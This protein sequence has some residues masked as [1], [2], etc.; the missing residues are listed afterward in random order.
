MAHWT[1]RRPSRTSACAVLTTLGAPPTLAEATRE[2]GS[3]D[4]PE[5]AAMPRWV[6]V[7]PAR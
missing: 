6:N 7:R 4:V 5:L 3:R 1:S 2:L